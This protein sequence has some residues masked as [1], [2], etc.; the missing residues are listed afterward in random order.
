[1]KTKFDN[2][3]SLGH[4]LGGLGILLIGIA[5]L[6]KSCKNDTP[7]SAKEYEELD[8]AISEVQK[9][10]DEVLKDPEMQEYIKKAIQDAPVE[11][12]KVEYKKVTK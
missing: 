1:M 3:K 2:L 12:K 6:M 10:L 9:E 8:E 5:V 7:V 11:I 4:F